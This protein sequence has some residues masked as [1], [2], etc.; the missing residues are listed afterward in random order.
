MRVLFKIWLV[1][2]FVSMTF[3][4]P[5]YLFSDNAIDAVEDVTAAQLIPFVS[6]KGADVEH[7]EKSLSRVGFD[8]GKS[9]EDALDDN[10]RLSNVTV[11]Y[12]DDALYRDVTLATGLRI[13][14]AKGELKGG[15]SLDLIFAV[16]N[17]RFLK[18]QTEVRGILAFQITDGKNTLSLDD[19]QDLQKHLYGLFYKTSKVAGESVEELE[20]R[21][22]GLLA[23]RQ[24]EQLEKAQREAKAAMPAPPEESVQDYFAQMLAEPKKKQEHA[25]ESQTVAGNPAPDKIIIFQFDGKPAYCADEGIDG[26]NCRGDGSAF[27]GQ[28]TYKDYKDDGSEICIAGEP[29]CRLPR[30][31][32]DGIKG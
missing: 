2:T 23:Q 9:L 30:Y 15:R 14:V 27:I 25:I 7:I 21:F 3:Y 22:N 31:F 29:D 8:T 19:P 1:A 11:E 10:P 13:V 28:G 12:G 16:L 26:P 32:P 6:I 4:A 24:Q 18:N 20:G 5:I 17:K